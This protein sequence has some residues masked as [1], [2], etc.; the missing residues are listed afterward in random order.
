M[1]DEPAVPSL[2]ARIAALNLQPNAG[3]L[4]PSYG[5]A[6][7][8]KKRPPPP[9][10]APPPR[11]SY[12]ARSESTNNPP[13]QDNGPT[14]ARG[15]GNLPMEAE[16]QRRILPPPTIS[17]P[18]DAPALPARP[19]L[20]P[21]P[22]S[23]QKSPALPP[24]RPSGQSI[25]RKESQESIST[26]AS[27]RST[28]SARSG[29]TS[30][31]GVSESHGNRMKAPPFDPSTLPKLPPKKSRAEKDADLHSVRSKYLNKSNGSTSPQPP[32][33][34]ARPALPNRPNTV[35]SAMTPR[36][37]RSALEWG[38]NK[39]TEQ[40]PPL[41]TRPGQTI[42]EEPPPLPM[43]SK[44]D[45]SALQASK[46]QPTAQKPCLKCRDFRAVD[47][48]AA[49]FPRE[50]I[51]SHDLG[52]L[53]HQLTDP[54][55][56]LTDKA[57]AIFSWLHHNIDYNT[58][59]FFA[60]NVKGSTP[61]S[62][63]ATGLAVCEG[64]A[65]LFSALAS[66]VGLE[67][68]VIGGHGKGFGHATLS[69]GSPVPPF[70]CGHA[71]NAVRIDDGEWKLIDCCWGAGYID[72]GSRSY[73]R[74]FKPAYFNMDNNE[75]GLK[76]FPENNRYFF[77]TDGRVITWE[78][79][80]MAPP[81]AEVYGFA[82]DQGIKQTSFQP[83]VREIR[84]YDPSPTAPP[85]I[86]F[87]FE[88]VC[89]HYNPEALGKGKPYMY[90]LCVEG[91]DGR[92]KQFLPFETNGQ[93]WWLDVQRMELGAPGQKIMI[94]AGTKWKDG[95]DGSGKGVTRQMYEMDKYGFRYYDGVCTWSLG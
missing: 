30:L 38:M 9:P 24:R 94:A 67:S 56:S 73:T 49:R 60:N 26:V 90:F 71:W 5:Q 72:G 92:N 59:D 81:G 4:P 18:N 68:V 28:F 76:H 63:I 79:Y 46:P 41:P 15:I 14:T 6:I 43:S 45:L 22:A 44:P 70:G 34:P 27:G 87:Q 12:D 61:A 8:A 58:R 7:G 55:P 57:R 77:R 54:F 25:Q 13:L 93:F 65:A 69:P 39:D 40:S 10:S 62:T 88:T 11:L 1:A 21:R 33:L 74:A 85:I 19:P 64:Y 36:P 91:R 95:G 52:W 32:S 16:N 23:M 29:G 50:A 37:R 17:R 78:E 66:Q 83:N 47:A 42:V 82:E 80:I 20:P 89:P 31:S 53:A 35:S 51:P 48:H 84:I 75:F 2:K 86:R 3:V